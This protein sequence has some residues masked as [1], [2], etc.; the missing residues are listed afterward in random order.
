MAITFTFSIFLLS[1]NSSFR[2]SFLESDII[3]TGFENCINTRTRIFH[4]FIVTIYSICK[5]KM[6]NKVADD[7][8]F[9]E[10]RYLQS[11]SGTNF[12]EHFSLAFFSMK[13]YLSSPKQTSTICA[14]NNIFGTFTPIHFIII[15]LLSSI[16]LRIKS[17]PQHKMSYFERASEHICM[18]LK[19]NCY[20]F[21]VKMLGF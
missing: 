13:L 3:V 9:I 1:K 7:A 15:Q 2:K 4:D 10:R 8:C 11:F 16:L 20:K 5:L 14:K 6:R 19:N 12:L 18:T 21:D 17:N